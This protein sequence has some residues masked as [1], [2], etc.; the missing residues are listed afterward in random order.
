V[1]VI[2]KSGA[3]VTVL[4][5]EGENALRLAQRFDVQMEGACE[6]SLACTTCHCYVDSERHWDM[7][8]SNMF[9]LCYVNL[10]HVALRCV[11]LN[12]DLAE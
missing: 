7:V 4:A 12:A 5:K 2:V 1:H 11:I 8:R 6:A 3:R 9:C 10:F